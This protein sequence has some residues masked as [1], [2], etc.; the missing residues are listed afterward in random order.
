MFAKYFAHTHKW[1]CLTFVLC[2][3][4]LDRQLGLLLDLDAFWVCPGLI[5]GG[6]CGRSGAVWMLGR[7]LGGLV[8]GKRKSKRKRIFNQK[9][10]PVAF[11]F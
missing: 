5:L 11:L 2:F 9:D 7:G 6:F 1:G 10:F 8:D 4:V 3:V